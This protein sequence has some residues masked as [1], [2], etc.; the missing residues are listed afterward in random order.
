MIPR[1][2]A[3]K[4]TSYALLSSTAGVF[5]HYL[6][7]GQY[8]LLQSGMSLW[9]YGIALALIA[10]VIPTYMLSYAM[11]KV[12]ST[13]VAIISSIGPVSTILQAHYFLGEKIFLLQIIGTLLVLAGVLLLVVK[14][15]KVEVV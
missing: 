4:F 15:K 2:G 7:R 11:K 13:K 1:I 5:I 6:V 9:W 3:N 12:G 8:D 14:R 10:T